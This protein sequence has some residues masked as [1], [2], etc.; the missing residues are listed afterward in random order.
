[1]EGTLA[2]DGHVQVVHYGHLFGN[3]VADPHHLQ[4]HMFLFFSIFVDC[5]RVL[6]P[7]L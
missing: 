2:H 5:V 6:P 4:A 1:M 3:T 7:S